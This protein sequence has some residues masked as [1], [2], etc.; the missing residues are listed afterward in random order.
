MPRLSRRRILQAAAASSVFPLFTVAGT[1][2]SGKVIGAND[3]IR[4]GVAGIHGRG[5]AHIDGFST[6]ANKAQVTCL[7]DPDSSLFDSRSK[8]VEQ[9]YGVRPKCVQ[10]I[11]QA[12]DDKEIDAISVALAFADYHLVVPG[13]QRRLRGKADQPQRV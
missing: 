9:K 5:G 10:D 11:R 1:K 2:A 8:T 12:L 7:I 3:T 13:G 4:I 6:P